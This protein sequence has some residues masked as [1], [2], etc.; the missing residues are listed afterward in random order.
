M[1]KIEENL[2][3]YLKGKPYINVLFKFLTK[4][5][6]WF[7]TYYESIIISTQ[8]RTVYIQCSLYGLCGLI[9]D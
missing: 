5:H 4:F 2:Y 8:V 9:R 6:L 3:T 1:L 7:Q